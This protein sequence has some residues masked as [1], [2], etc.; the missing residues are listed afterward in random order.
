MSIGVAAVKAAHGW[1]ITILSRNAVSADGG[2]ETVAGPT[3]GGNP[4]AGTP[5][6]RRTT[7]VF[8]AGIQQPRPGHIQ[9]TDVSH[10]EV[11]SRPR[12]MHPFGVSRAVISEK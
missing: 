11:V 7:E 9:N 4:E 8:D 3:G 2:N 6:G 5:T 1:G 10:F 12:N